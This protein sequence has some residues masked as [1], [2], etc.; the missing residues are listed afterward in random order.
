MH[1]ACA[2]THA[3]PSKHLA[4][5]GTHPP[6]HRPTPPHS[7]APLPAARALTRGRLQL[8]QGALGGCVGL[9]Y[10]YRIGHAEVYVPW[11]WQQSVLLRAGHAVICSTKSGAQ[12]G[13]VWRLGPGGVGGPFPV[14]VVGWKKMPV[15]AD[16]PMQVWT[17]PGAGNMW[18]PPGPAYPGSRRTHGPAG[19]GRSRTP[20]GLRAG[21]RVHPCGPIGRLALSC[22]L[23]A[24]LTAS[25]AAYAA[26]RHL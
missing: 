13:L 23:G 11:R 2:R 6:T 19:G 3:R 1:A 8:V 12:G 5:A 25:A 24:L 4:Q 20:T 21:R 18:Q 22:T 10:H 17:Q 16:A 15:H 14:H 9:V 26:P 7:T